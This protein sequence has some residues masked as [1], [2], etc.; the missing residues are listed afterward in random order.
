MTE[1]NCHVSDPSP[2]NQAKH[3]ILKDLGAKRVA[4]WCGVEEATVYQWL[5]RGSDA[6]PIPPAR[7]AAIV[8]GARLDGLEAPI[9][10]L[11]PAMAPATAG[12]EP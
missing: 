9:S 2:R 10:V 4:G 1:T 7:V 12:V 5:S 3:L 6:K 11:W 8:N